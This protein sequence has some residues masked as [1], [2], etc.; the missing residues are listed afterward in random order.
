MSNDDDRGTLA[1]RPES[2]Y[3][4][5]TMQPPASGGPLQRFR[6]YWQRL[7]IE[8]RR[9]LFEEIA[10]LIHAQERAAHAK[11]DFDKACVK[12]EQ[13]DEIRE[14]ERFR[15]RAEI[16][17]EYN[18]IVTDL[19]QSGLTLDN[20]L[21][22]IKR[23]ASPPTKT[24]ERRDPNEDALRATLRGGRYE[25][26]AEKE[27]EDFVRERGG[28]ENLNDEDKERIRNTRRLA[29]ELDQSRGRR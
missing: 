3:S 23:K 11:V 17:T 14:L 1:R 7:N 4:L 18:R 15:V 5:T 9:K 20:L 27:I 26:L 21:D 28:E 16:S 10:N 2:H 13:L 12:L 22:E 29:A 6:D 25:G 19:L 24:Q 8:Q